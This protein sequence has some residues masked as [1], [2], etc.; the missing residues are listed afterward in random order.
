MSKFGD[1]MRAKREE[2]FEKRSEKRLKRVNT[3]CLKKINKK[4]EKIERLLESI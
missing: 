3:Y 4:L 2:R 1:K